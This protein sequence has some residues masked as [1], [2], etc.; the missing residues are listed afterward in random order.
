MHHLS[1]AWRR[2]GS[3][4]RHEFH[5]LAPLNAPRAA[6][7]AL[8]AHFSA[9]RYEVRALER[10]PAPIAWRDFKSSIPGANDL[11]N[12]AGVACE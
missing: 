8:S 4:V 6:C 10:L 11:H 2:L 1:D 5:R 3:W 7:G 12:A 9:A